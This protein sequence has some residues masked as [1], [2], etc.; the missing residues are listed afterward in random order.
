M[1]LHEVL[2]S[3]LLLEMAYTQKKA[4]RVVT[5]LEKPINDHL[6]KLWT[7]PNSGNRDVWKNDL[8]NWIEEVAEI[9]LRPTN[10]R[11]PHTFYYKLL[12]YEPFGGGAEISNILRRLRRLHCTDFPM[13]IDV[14]PETLVKRLRTFH[15]DLSSLCAVK[16]MRE[17]QIRTFLDDH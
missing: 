13:Q 16:L 6:L 11:P 14:M 1:Q 5:A 15:R 10:T 7:I 9:V 17:D 4:E 12:F 2:D 8:V 3:G